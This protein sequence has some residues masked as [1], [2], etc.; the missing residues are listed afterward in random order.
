[1]TAFDAFLALVFNAE[2]AT[3]DL[4]PR[5]SG[6]WTGGQ[7]G[8]GALR[9]S[10]RGISAAAYPGLDIG[11][12]TDAQAAAI[13]RVDYWQRVAADRLPPPVA[14]FVADEAVNQ[15]IAAA[16]RDLQLAL[17]LTADGVVGPVTIAAA[18]RA[19][20]AALLDELL[21]R[22]ALRY[23]QTGPALAN[24]GLGWMRR[25]AAAVRASRATA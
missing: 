9:G 15:G 25:L 1:M 21:A 12:L 14:V 17:G 3:L 20:Q 19:D 16:A 11:G 23:A 22:R 10:R 8:K 7:V 5:D 2:G 4:D 18:A 13:Y 24:F 6:N